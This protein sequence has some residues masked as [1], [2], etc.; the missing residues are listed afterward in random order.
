M[1]VDY[2]AVRLVL[3]MNVVYMSKPKVTAEELLYKIEE[4]IRD[5]TGLNLGGLGLY[6]V[7]S[8]G[9]G[10]IAEIRRGSELC[11]DGWQDMV[12]E[13]AAALHLEFDLCPYSDVPPMM[14][15]DARNFARTRY[16]PGH[17]LREEIFQYAQC[18]EVGPHAPRWVHFRRYRKST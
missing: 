6:I 17:R 1:L 18:S 4:K 12:D 5:R 15:E 3:D 9:G 10:W 2:V 11:Q 13:I 16:P 14:A 8:E 7:R